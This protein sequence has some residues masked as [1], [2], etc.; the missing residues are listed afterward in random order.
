MNRLAHKRQTGER[1]AARVRSTI[2]QTAQR[3][4]LCVQ[5]SNTHISAQ[6]IDDA[7][8]ITLASATS[9]GQKLTGSMSEKAAVVGKQ[10]GE[11][12][13]KAKVKKVV[14]DRGGKKYHGRVKS[15][16]DAARNAG[17]EF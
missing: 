5:I 16:A 11:A 7:K 4:R 3:P 2:A 14:F 13:K 10:I 6:I 15:L 12:G 1:R 17:L 8:G 9:M